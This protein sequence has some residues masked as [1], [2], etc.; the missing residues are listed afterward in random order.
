MKK[1]ETDTLGVAKDNLFTHFGLT[2]KLNVHSSYDENNTQA[3]NFN[4][5]HTHT[6]NLIHSKIRGQTNR[7]E[8]NTMSSKKHM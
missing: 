6:R 5:L 8:I 4:Q 3:T 2:R 7:K 1:T